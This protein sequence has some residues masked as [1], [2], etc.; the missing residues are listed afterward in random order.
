MEAEETDGWKVDYRPGGWARAQHE[1]VTVY[2][3]LR[4]DE[5]ARPRLRFYAGALTADRPVT[6]EMWRSVPLARLDDQIWVLSAT[7]TPDLDETFRELILASDD[8]SVTEL[9]RYFAE[10]PALPL[11]GLLVRNSLADL[12]VRPS[13]GRLSDEFLQSVAK[14]YLHAVAIGNA[15]APLIAD[16]AGAPVRTVHR[17]VAEARRREILPPAVRGRAG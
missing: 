8:M 13:D 9:D 16:A 11:T 15:P 7:S 2:L 12:L 6:E 4:L 3:R 1:G 5:G 14:I 17:W 10:T